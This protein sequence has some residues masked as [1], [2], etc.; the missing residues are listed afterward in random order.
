MPLLPREP[1]VFPPELFN[2]EYLAQHTEREWWGLYTLARREEEPVRALLGSGAS[3]Y[4]PVVVKR[5]RAP[6]GRVHV[7][8]VPLFTSYVFLHGDEMARYRALTTRCVSHA[9]AVKDSGEMT[10]Q[11][12]QIERLISA[13]CDL[14][15][16]R[17]IASGARVRM[18]RGP[19]CGIEGT[20]FRDEGHSRLFVAV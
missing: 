7:A 1:N 18:R 6:S 5:T 20:M 13:G 19:L 2:P 14:Q 17:H 11:L 15:H 3:F 12:Q 8:H 4:C 9:L 16:H 10:R